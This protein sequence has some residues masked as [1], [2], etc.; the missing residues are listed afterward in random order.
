MAV[1]TNTAQGLGQPSRGTCLSSLGTTAIALAYNAGSG[2]QRN[3]LYVPSFGTHVALNIYS[4]GSTSGVSNL[5]LWAR[6]PAEARNPSRNWPIDLVA[7]TGM[8]PGDAELW[9]PLDT[10]T[11][12]GPDAKFGSSS[13]FV[14]PV[15]T[16]SL[17][18][19]E[20]ITTTAGNLAVGQV[21]VARF[22]SL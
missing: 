13:A 20:E 12:T 1:I 16:V 4:S 8:G 5:N 2:T 3:S 6:V 17:L 11:I 14:G 18:G 7:G 19:A 21:L 9:F 15:E 10:L 22:I